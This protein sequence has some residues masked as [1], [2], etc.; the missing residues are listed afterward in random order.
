M[1]IFINAS[2]A[3]M[4]V[5]SSL[6]LVHVPTY[7]ATCATAAVRYSCEHIHS[8]ERL[9]SSGGFRG[10]VKGAPPAISGNVKE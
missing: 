7:I 6:L 4:C 3:C 5:P 2:Q 8:N 1:H 10:V 9:H